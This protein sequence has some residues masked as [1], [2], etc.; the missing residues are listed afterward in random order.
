M[1]KNEKKRDELSTYLASFFTGEGDPKQG[2]WDF[3]LKHGL[4][5]VDKDLIEYL[6][7][8]DIPPAVKSVWNCLN[9]IMDLHN[10]AVSDEQDP[11]KMGDNEL[12]KKIIEMYRI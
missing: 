9:Y 2:S 6:Q 1:D 10:S 3:L 11:S 5:A 4:D 8:E 7:K 12:K